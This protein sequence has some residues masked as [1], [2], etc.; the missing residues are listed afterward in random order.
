MD[1]SRFASPSLHPPPTA[2]TDIMEISS[3]TGRDGGYGDIEIDMDFPTVPV[4]EDSILEDVRPEISYEEDHPAS[5]DDHIMRDDDDQSLDMN[6]AEPLDDDTN[7]QLESEAVEMS[8]YVPDAVPANAVQSGSDHEVADPANATDEL[9]WETLDEPQQDINDQIQV[10]T[11]ETVDNEQL[12]ENVDEPLTE[13]TP[14]ASEVL[15][16]E[17]EQDELQDYQQYEDQAGQQEQYSEEQ[18]EEQ[19][20]KSPSPPNESVAAASEQPAENGVHE[21]DTEFQGSREQSVEEHRSPVQVTHETEDTKS[22]HPDDH[23]PQDTSNSEAWSLSEFSHNIV[24]FYGQTGYYSLLCNSESDDPNNY[25]L[26]DTSLFGQPIHDFLLALRNVIDGELSPDDEVCLK[27]PD[28]HL[29]ISEVS[30][31]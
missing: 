13:A 5:N 7:I 15:E 18:R 12:R 23:N 19:T 1:T 24:V 2:D 30:H 11:Q 26:R 25:F 20:R 31:P 3:D 6:D 4:D 29:E 10:S 8:F 16:D 22:A 9:T 27:V 21:H 28:L 14:A 17:Y